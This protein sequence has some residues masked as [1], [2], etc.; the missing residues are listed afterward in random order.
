[1]QGFRIMRFWNNDVMQNLEG[2]AIRLYETLG[3]DGPDPH[4]NPS[5]QGGGA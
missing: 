3:I 1:M 4:P 2:A 5:P